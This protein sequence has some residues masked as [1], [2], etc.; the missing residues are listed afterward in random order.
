MADKDDDSTPIRVG[1]LGAGW[2]GREAHLRN[3]LSLPGV[4]VLA[5]SSRSD[6]SL[7]AALDLAGSHLRTF[8]DWRELLQI[9]NL[10]AVVIALTNDQHHEAALAAFDAG[11]H[12]LCEKP[13]GLTVK[14]CDEIIAA[15]ESAGKLLQIGHE[16]RF[17]RLYQEMKAMIDGG[18]IGDPQLMWCRE[19]RGPMRPGWRS[20]ESLTGGTILEKNVHH[21][22]LFNWMMDREPVRVAAQGGTNVLTDREILDNAQV[23]IEYEGGRR[24]T[25]ELCLFAPY[26]GDCEIGAAGDRGRIDTKNQAL[27]LV[28]HRFDLPDRLD[29][30]IADSK[31]DAN[32]VDAA[33][34]VD[35]GIR[36]ELIHFFDCIREGKTPL[37]DGP[38]ARRAVAVC[39]AAQESIR[40]REMVD[41]E[42]FCS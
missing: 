10:D 1:L 34:R 36:P 9:E 33:G 35:R 3:L 14:Q 5:A 18:A 24:A 11:L 27:S 19:F 31:D 4:E 23:L 16:M 32:F 21:I 6:A 7:R 15:S 26:G 2:F 29:M 39:L 17:Q 38:S 42:E 22:D 37:N 13:L 28:H 25:L 12:V 8:E 30:R 40:R 41:L 20:S